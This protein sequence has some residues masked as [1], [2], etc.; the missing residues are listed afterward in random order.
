MRQSGT[1]YGPFTDVPRDI[2]RTELNKEQFEARVEIWRKFRNQTNI[3]IRIER[4]SDSL[5]VWDRS[6]SARDY[7]DVHIPYSRHIETVRGTALNCRVKD[8]FFKP[9]TTRPMIKANYDAGQLPT[10]RTDC[11]F[12]NADDTERGVFVI[13]DVTDSEQRNECLYRDRSGLMTTESWR[14]IPLFKSDE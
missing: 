7:F 13:Y 14:Y 11:G 4:T 5:R 12:A 6:R 8:V 2:P 3:D 10:K 1:I 9:Y